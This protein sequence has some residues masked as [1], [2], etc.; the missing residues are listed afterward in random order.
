VA[1]AVRR[2]DGIEGF[3]EFGGINSLYHRR[4]VPVKL[5]NGK[6]V[7]AWIYE[8]NRSVENLR[9]IKSGDWCK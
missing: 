3:Y 7:L 9:Q 2:L 4:I 8:Y 5:N 1:A 6:T